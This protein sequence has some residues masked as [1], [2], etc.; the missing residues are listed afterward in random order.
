VLGFLYIAAEW[1]IRIG[2]TPVVIRKRDTS[3]S[4]AWLAFIY[5]IPFVGAVVYFFIGEVELGKRRGARHREATA[6]LREA[7]DLHHGAEAV[8]GVV[9]A[10]QED[11]EVLCRRVGGSPA[12]GGNAVEPL[13]DTDAFLSRLSEEIDGAESSVHLLYYIFGTVGGAE[14]VID[15]IERAAARGVRCRVLVDAVGSRR[16]MKTAAPRLRK[17]GAECASC[18]PVGVFRRALSRIDL[19][20]HRKLAVIDGRAAYVGSHNAI[21]ADYGLRKRDGV[22][23]V[24]PWHDLS[25]RIEGPAVRELQAVFLE[26]WNAETHETLTSDELFGASVSGETAIQVSP[27]GPS[28]RP[29]AFRWLVSA[30]LHEAEERVVI[31]SPY[32]ALDSG[33]L[34]ALQLTAM[35]GVSVSLVLPEKSNS[36]LAAGA[37][38][39]CYGMLLESGVRIYLH[40]DGLLHAKTMTIDDAF[41]LGGSGNFDM[42]SFLLNFELTTILYG[43]VATTR[44]REQQERYIAESRELTREEW[45][46]RAGWKHTLDRLAM[47]AS[48]LL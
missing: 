41:T 34:R 20:N 25:A 16:F 40:Q 18:L 3:S 37:C 15:A 1:L 38:R 17:A 35:R 10:A 31:T 32:L 14:R 5:F 9:P 24:G 42:R 13:A 26:D 22:L 33:T 4:L 28:G 46:A 11:F 19:R 48:P 29:A 27:S 36:V 2:M 6:S 12:L 39:A 23:K 21:D 43:E 45:L 47:L 30:A 44:V 7:L 8:D